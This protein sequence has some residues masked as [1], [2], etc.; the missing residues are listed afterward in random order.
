VSLLLRRRGGSWAS[1]DLTEEAVRSIRELVT[2]DVHLVDGR[3]LPFPDGEF[4]AV[5]VV[6]MLE[7]VA[8]D[9]AFLAELFR[10]TRPAGRLVVNTPHRRT[11][12]LRRLRHR[13]GQTDEEHGH[14]RPGYT[15][16]ELQGLVEADGRFLLDRHRTYSGFFSELIDTGIQW[17]LSRLGKKGSAKGVV[18]M[19]GDLRRHRKLFLAYSA[20]YPFVL[21]VSQLDRL[22]P[23]GSGYMLIASAR[24]RD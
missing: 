8:D 24:R 14:V 7:H 13:L 1:A 18:V 19:A 21:A 15:M 10:I 16:A 12:R 17:G 23:A 2:T 5:V 6:D 20:L 3:R 11:T 4:D 9:R 22:L